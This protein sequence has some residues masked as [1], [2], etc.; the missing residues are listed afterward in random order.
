MAQL[1]QD[2]LWRIFDHVD[3]HTLLNF[4]QS[5]HLRDVVQGYLTHSYRHITAPFVDDPDELTRILRDGGAIIGGTA[6]SLFTR[7][8]SAGRIA[9]KLDIYTPVAGAEDMTA[10]LHYQ[11]YHM[12]ETI[13]P[14]VPMDGINRELLQTR[15][16]VRAGDGR[17]VNVLVSRTNSPV[18]C[19]LASQLTTSMCV[20][21]G[22]VFWAAYSNDVLAAQGYVNPSVFSDVVLGQQATPQR[23][24]A[25]R[26]LYEHM[27]F[28]VSDRAED[29]HPDHSCG[30]DS[31]CPHTLRVTDDR[32]CLKIPLVPE[33]SIPMEGHPG[34]VMSRAGFRVRWRLGGPP[35][36]LGGIASERLI[37]VMS[38]VAD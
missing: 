33:H 36:R 17:R 31:A 2:V 35:C 15:V 19:V 34:V 20:F 32:I 1:N 11:R 6:A 29:I 38:G 24:E 3:L 5:T 27:G 9:D 7:A 13:I 21:T 14:N 37:E 12:V 26:I 10:Y 28:N 25:E 8:F 30:Q 4:Q 18:A 16:F 22:Y 23:V